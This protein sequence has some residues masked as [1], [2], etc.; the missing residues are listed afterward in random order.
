MKKIKIAGNLIV[1]WFLHF[2]IYNTYYGWNLEPLTD[3][4]KMWD[5]VSSVFLYICFFFYMT[6]LLKLYEDAIKRMEDRQNA[7]SDPVENCIY[8]Q[9]NTTAMNCKHCG[10]GKHRH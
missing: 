10:Q 5:T 8:E 7:V 4:E 6:P 9:D 3:M 2:L 1:I